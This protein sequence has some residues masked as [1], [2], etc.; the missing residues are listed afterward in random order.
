MAVITLPLPLQSI[1]RGLTDAEKRMVDGVF[2]VGTIDYN[3]VRIVKRTQYSKVDTRAI[4]PFGF[5][6]YPDSQY[7]EDFSSSKLT[8]RDKHTFIHEMTHVWQYQLN[9][10][11]AKNGIVLQAQYT[12]GKDVY[13]YVLDKAKRLKDYNLEQQGEIVA[14][15]YVL[16]HLSGTQDYIWS[17]LSPYTLSG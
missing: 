9:Y 6:I 10:S 13:S 16:F 14:D 15:Y 4:A 11:V 12:S 8:A 7:R 2:G 17:G 1:G 5:I 3:K